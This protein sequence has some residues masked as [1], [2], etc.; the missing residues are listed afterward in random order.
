MWTNIASYCL[1]NDSCSIELLDP[2]DS[3]SEKEENSEE[4]IDQEIRSNQNLASLF[5][6]NASHKILVY[7]A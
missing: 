5:A 6:F 4:K 2:F 7:E 3:E 1:I